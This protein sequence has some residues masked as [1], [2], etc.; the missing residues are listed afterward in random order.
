[1]TGSGEVTRLLRRIR[2]GQNGAIDEVFPVVYEELK[3]IARRHLARERSGHTLNTTALVHEVYLKLMD[4]DTI[5]WQDRAHFRAVA[6]RAMRRIL[7]D[8]ARRRKAQKRGGGGSR[9]TLDDGHIAVDDQAELI[10]SLDQAME[11][12]AQLDERLCTV[13]EYRF[14]GA[15]QEEEIAEVLQVSSRTVRRDWVKARAWLFKELYPEDL[16]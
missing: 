7:V 8:Y 13:V 5:P 9:L 4:R 11:R 14:F 15:M 10:V 3:A 16:D 6:S 12:L 2:E 1:M